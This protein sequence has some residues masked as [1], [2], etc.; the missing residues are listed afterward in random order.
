MATSKWCFEVFLG[1]QRAL[2]AILWAVFL[3][4]KVVFCIVH[5]SKL[6][7]TILV[8]NTNKP[9]L[10]N[11]NAFLLS[12]KE[13]QGRENGPLAIFTLI[14]TCS[15]FI[16]EYLISW[17]YLLHR[18]T[19]TS[20]LGDQSVHCIKS[21]QGLTCVCPNLAVPGPPREPTTKVLGVHTDRALVPSHNTIRISSLIRSYN[22]SSIDLNT[23]IFLKMHILH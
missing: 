15:F 11:L 18:H 3:P 1:S 6:R 12:M 19:W 16:L 2:S 7:W 17:V 4:E 23:Y 9:L 20:Q 10:I 13:R 8:E 22:L 5:S 14:K 21:V